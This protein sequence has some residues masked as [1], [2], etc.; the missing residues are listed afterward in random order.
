MANLKIWL[1][2]AENDFGEFIEAMI[3]GQH[4]FARWDSRPSIDEN[5]LLA[6]EDGLAKVDKEYY[7]HGDPGCF[8]LFAWTKSRVFFL[9]EHDGSTELVWVPR[10]PVDIAP[11]FCGRAAR[12][13]D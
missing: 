8:P 3:V 9:S 6:R 13:G 1:E 2:Q 7:C 4:D 12:P 5:V 10:A 11:T